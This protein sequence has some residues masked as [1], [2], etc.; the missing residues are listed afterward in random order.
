[1]DGF[2]CIGNHQI[3]QNIFATGTNRVGLTWAP[4]I[5]NQALKWLDGKKF[6]TILKDGILIEI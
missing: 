5:V 3:Y 2:P 6:Q 4:E 1:M